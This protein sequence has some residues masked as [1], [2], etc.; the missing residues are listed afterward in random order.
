MKLS[1]I[2][3]YYLHHPQS[4]MD[5]SEETRLKMDAQELQ[6]WIKQTGEEKD[7]NLTIKWDKNI[8]VIKT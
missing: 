6:E 7:S 8:S 3:P 5:L 1:K 2:D 4:R